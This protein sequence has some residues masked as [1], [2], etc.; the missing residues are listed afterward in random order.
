MC[1]IFNLHSS[2]IFYIQGNLKIYIKILIMLYLMA[3][4][5]EIYFLKYLF[6]FSQYFNQCSNFHSFALS[7]YLKNLF[8]YKLL[9]AL[10]YFIV[11]SKIL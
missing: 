9:L 1:I 6:I 11:T 10:K 5:M 8:F 2:L 7:D 4:I 3:F